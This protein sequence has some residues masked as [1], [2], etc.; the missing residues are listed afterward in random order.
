VRARDVARRLK[1]RT[2]VRVEMNSFR[3]DWKEEATGS[4]GGNSWTTDP[5]FHLDDGTRV[6]FAVAE[7][8]MGE[9]GI[10]VCVHGGPKKKA[11]YTLDGETLEVDGLERLLEAN[12]FDDETVAKDERAPPR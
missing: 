1:G 3:T 7:T 4:R 2:I 8:E 9:Y 10:D 11:V 5:V 6:S 12:T